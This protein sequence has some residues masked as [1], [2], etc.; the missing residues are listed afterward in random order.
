MKPTPILSLNPFQG[1]NMSG[2]PVEIAQNESPDL[3]NVHVGENGALN[4]RTG[5]ERVMNLSNTGTGS[6]KGMFLY[7]KS[8]GSEIFLVAHGGKLYSSSVPNKGTGL[9]A[10]TDDDLSQTWESEV[11]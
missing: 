1:I 2:S 11:Q 3:L 10:W 4:K 9:A 7:R 8:N 5:Y 6:I